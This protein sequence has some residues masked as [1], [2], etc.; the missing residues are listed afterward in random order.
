MTQRYKSTIALFAQ[1]LAISLVVIFGSNANVQAAT[2]N[3]CA[4]KSSDITKFLGTPFLEG[5][6]ESGGFGPSCQYKSKGNV[7]SFGSDISLQI[8][9]MPLNGT[10]ESMKMFFG[11]RD[12]KYTP[13]AN[14][15]DKAVTVTGSQAFKVPTVPD[16]IYVRNGQVVQLTIRGGI[17]PESADK[18]KSLVDEYNKKLLALPRIP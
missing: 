14:D 10:F 4:L 8:N 13:V 7:K 2:P 15:P 3:A 11:P 9:I 16:I 5:K 6:P 18:R 12:T 1:A 17:Y